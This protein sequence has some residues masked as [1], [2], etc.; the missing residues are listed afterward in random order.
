MGRLTGE[1][2]AIA[3]AILALYGLLF[4]VVGLA[5]EPAWRTAIF[6]LAGT[7]GLAF[8]S[9]VAGYFWARWYA[10][11]IGLSGLASAVISIWQ[12]GMEPVLLIYG[13]TH[14]AVSLLLWGNG[15][16]S[17]FDGREEWRARFHLDET[18]TNRLGRAVI[19]LGI[20][21]PYVI[22]Y[23]LAPREGMATTLLALGGV[24]LVAVGGR[25]LVSLRS[26]SVVALAGAAALLALAIPAS[27]SIVALGNGY[28]LTIGALGLAGAV[29]LV[30]AIAPLV[31]PM[32]RYLATG[33]RA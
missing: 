19:R 25:A 23:G 14:A 31:G 13:G 17:G 33:R 24:A 18:A 4:L 6:A 2:K 12:L 9:I 15:M 21:L 22:L 26:W 8:F 32:A 3:A 7:Y 11:G 30:A 10:V 20:S 1:R 29:L 28:A 27:P 5:G 16:A